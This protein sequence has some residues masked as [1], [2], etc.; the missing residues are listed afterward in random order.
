MSSERGNEAGDGPREALESDLEARC[1]SVVVAGA[2]YAMH[3]D[4]VQEVNGLRPLTRV[5]HSP[6]AIAGV[7]S[8]R[9]EV[10]PVLDLGVL[11]GAGS[12]GR[13]H[14]ARVLVVRDG[15]KR[16]AGLLVDALAGLR[17]IAESGLEALP[18]T[19]SPAVRELSEGVIADSPACVV[20]RVSALLSAPQIAPAAAA[21]RD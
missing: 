14:E 6:A 16:R 20:L 8:L 2:H 10:L 15:S 4:D 17:E 7:T 19:L 21:G 3:L 11:L 1:I 18:S 13:G 9:G 5:F 12:S